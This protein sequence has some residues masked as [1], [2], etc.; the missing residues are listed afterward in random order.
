MDYSVCV[1]CVYWICPWY[2]LCIQYT[3]ECEGQKGEKDRVMSGA[4]LYMVHVHVYMKCIQLSEPHTPISIDVYLVMSY[5]HTLL[6]SLS[7]VFE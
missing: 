1:C 4:R 5:L 6:H 3:C 2:R 7:N